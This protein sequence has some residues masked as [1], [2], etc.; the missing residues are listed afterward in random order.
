MIVGNAIGTF[1]GVLLVGDTLGLNDGY[2]VGLCVGIGDGWKVGKCEGIREGATNVGKLE[3]SF[4]D[5][6]QVGKVEIGESVRWGDIVG[7]DEDCIVGL[8]VGAFVSKCGMLV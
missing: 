8:L 7:L 2:S 4:E 5:G 1:V 3:G 6:D